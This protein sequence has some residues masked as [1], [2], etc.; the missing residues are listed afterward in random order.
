M[1][2]LPPETGPV[3]GPAEG[4]ALGARQ[5]GQR[6]LLKSAFAMTIVTLLSRVLGLV[7]EQV[8]SYFL[9]TGAG[10]DAFGLASTIPNLLRRLFAEG[11]TT[12]AFVPVFTETMKRESRTDLWVFASR[13]L[14][15]LTIV[16]TIVTCIGILL[17][18]WLV[19]TFFA[20]GFQE[21]PGKVA[22]TI[23]L[24]QVMFP[25]LT[26]ISIAAVIQGILNSFHIFSPSAF[27]SVLLNIA[28]IACAA[29]LS[30]VFPDPSYAFA[31]GFLVG[32]VAQIAFQLPWLRQVGARL[33][34]TA[35]FWSPR[36]RRTLAI[37]APGVFSAGI[38]QI[39]V[40]V[41]QLVASRLHEGSIAALQYSIR[42][43]ELVLGVFVISLTT[44]ILPT[45]S[46]QLVDEDRTEARETLRFSLG[47]LALVTVPATVGL[48][49]LAAPV[50]R[51]LFQ[52]GEFD[53]ASTHM[54]AVALYFHTLGIYPIAVGRVV[55][56]AFFAMEDQ[57]TPM[58]VGALS[59]VVNV[60]LCFGLPPLLDPQAAHGGV[61]LAGSVAAAVNALVLVVL[62]R[63]RLGRI[64]ARALTRSFARIL[65]AAAVM[66][67]GV[68]ALMRL[69]D[70]D[71]ATGRLVL[72][73]KVVVATA[74]G[75]ALFLGA[76]RAVRTPELGELRRLVRRKA[77]RLRR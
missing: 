37:M 3:A 49:L 60:A 58:L 63:G 5:A 31:T 28:I 66:G 56:Q 29:A 1:V 44:V 13:F 77:A 36:V 6:R 64:G 14:T 59:M 25:Y 75:V 45:L 65:F 33:R 55:Q 23:V 61:A 42:L 21:V 57:R 38:Y 8:R 15:L 68:W 27:T 40:F 32:G 54:T 35:H 4:D 62:L 74:L 26:L 67:A 9:G 46:A 50:T 39:N 19:H 53:A 76:A 71:A 43:Q 47:L 41:S 11:A 18:P 12:A 73:L 24:T 10:S 69:W 51:L 17:S 48:V 34:P 16:V 30:D 70:F 20:E 2:D 72:A 7:R 22:L 52:H